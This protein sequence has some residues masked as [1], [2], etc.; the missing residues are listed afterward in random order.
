M[1]IAKR[2][3]QKEESEVKST[4]SEATISEHGLAALIYRQRQSSKKALAKIAREN[5][6]T[7]SN[8]TFK[9]IW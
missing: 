6:V 1:K 5:G 3:S 2:W 7:R 9:A 4:F 8:G